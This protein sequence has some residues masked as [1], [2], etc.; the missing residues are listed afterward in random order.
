VCAAG[1]ADGGGHPRPHQAGKP[2]PPSAVA[3]ALRL[4]GIG[5]IARNYL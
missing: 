2:F 3:V 5:L 1:R 4:L